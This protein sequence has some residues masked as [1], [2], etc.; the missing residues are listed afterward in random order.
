[1]LVDDNEADNYY[2][3]M[4]IEEENIS[5]T[6]TVVENGQ[7]ALDFLLS[8]I[9][10]GY[11]LPDIIFLDINMPVMNGWEFLEEYKKLDEIKHRKIIVVMLTTSFNP[12]DKNKS[13]S[14]PVISYFQNKPLTA[15]LIFK[16]VNEHFQD[17]L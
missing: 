10:D 5:E 12:D 1:M 13:K 8:C 16:I 17:Y 9:N 3:T 7:K 14:V 4:I 11:S 2:H 6:V 15:E